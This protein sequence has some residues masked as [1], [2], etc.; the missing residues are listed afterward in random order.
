[1]KRIRPIALGPFDYDRP[2]VTDMLWVSEGFTVYYEYLML[3]R[4]GRMTGQ[5]LLDA[6]GRTIAASEN[7]AGSALPVRH[8]VEP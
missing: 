7:N 5:E 8:D 6:L 2:N 4:S 3:A 1:M